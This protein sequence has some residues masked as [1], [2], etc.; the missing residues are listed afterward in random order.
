ML[1]QWSDTPA[2]AEKVL[3][4]VGKI[5][6]Y[7]TAKKYRS[8]ENPA[9]VRGHFEFLARPVVPTVEHHPAMK[10]ADIPGFMRE[11]VSDGS[12]EAKALAFL[13]LT[14]SRSAEVIG[15][16]W[17]EIAGTVFTC[18]AER[19]K[20][21]PKD[22]RPHSVPL[23]PQAL[24]LLGKRGAPDDFIFAGRYGASNPIAHDAMR[25]ALDRLRGKRLSIEGLPPVPHG[26]RSTFRDWA[27]EAGYDRD[28]AE[29]AIAHK[30]GNKTETAYQ[31]S[32]LLEQRRPLMNAWAKFAMSKVR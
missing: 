5:L 4:R 1:K 25:E 13:I 24:K 23:S 8:G 29:R 9:R 16:K 22:R 11:L 19:M 26:F 7:A 31:R 14:G 15:A 3:M 30:V 18:P 2:T 21:K 12:T 32:K 17:K 10:S 20:G 27:A 6:N 28:L